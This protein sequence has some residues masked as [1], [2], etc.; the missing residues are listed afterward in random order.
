[1]IC[2]P[3]VVQLLG[4]T[5]LV[6]PAL[7]LYNLFG[8]VEF[9]ESFVDR[10]HKSKG[11]V[12][13]CEDV[14]ELGE[15]SL[16]DDAD[17]HVFFHS[18]I[19]ARGFHAGGRVLEVFQDLFVDFV[20]MRSDD[21]KFQRRFTAAD[22]GI[23]DQAVQKAVQHTKADGLIIEDQRPVVSALGVNKEGNKGN[24]GIDRKIDPEEIENGI[25]LAHVFCHDVRAARTGI[26]AEGDPVHKAA[27]R[28]RDEHGIDGV[29][30]LGV[31]LQV[32]KLFGKHLQDNADH[33]IDE[34]EQKSLDGK[35]GIDQKESQDAQRCVDEDGKVADVEAEFIFE[36]GTDPVEA[37]GCKV[38]FHDEKLVVAGR[39][40][41][42][43]HHEKT[44]KV[45]SLGS[46]E[47]HNSLR[48]I[49]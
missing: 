11:I 23:A 43:Y 10:F 2:T 9:P 47:F 12:V 5:S 38:I 31:V 4:C 20:R 32:G 33:R 21:E 24:G 6:A 49:V 13:F 18:R 39:N 8:F 1:M 46:Y 28:S 42:E 14:L 36:H 16:V 25:F 19:G 15:L 27:H 26:S 40:D 22:D 29:D 45:K 3:K 30:S 35:F 48:W 17:D 34:T 7:L 37:C 44:V 41:R